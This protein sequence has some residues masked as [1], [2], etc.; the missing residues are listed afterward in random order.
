MVNVNQH[1]EGNLHRRLDWNAFLAQLF[2]QPTSN[3]ILFQRKCQNSIYL[4]PR[5]PDSNAK[6]QRPGNLQAEP[7]N[8]TFLAADLHNWSGGNGEQRFTVVC[9]NLLRWAVTQSVLPLTSMLAGE[10][11]QRIYLIVHWQRQLRL[12]INMHFQ[13]AL[14]SHQKCMWKASSIWPAHVFYD[15]P[16]LEVPRSLACQDVCIDRGVRDLTNANT[17]SHSVPL[18]VGG[19]STYCDWRRVLFH[20]RII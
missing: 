15:L 14:L 1:Q 10:T 12:L 8:S 7:S 18:S 6:L 19:V 4:T 5:A 20:S 16:T 11:Q 2:L 13:S 17:I 9:P 3:Q